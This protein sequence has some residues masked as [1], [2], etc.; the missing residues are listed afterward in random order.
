MNERLYSPYLFLHDKQIDVLSK[1]LKGPK[2]NILKHT[3]A[4]IHTVCQTKPL[5]G[6]LNKF[7]RTTAVSPF[8]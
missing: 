5:K 6:H 3:H 4:S 1:D 2:L 8:A 7:R